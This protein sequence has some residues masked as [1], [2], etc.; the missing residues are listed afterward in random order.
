MTTIY[1]PATSIQYDVDLF[2]SDL[3]GYTSDNALDTSLGDGT[4]WGF[5]VL[6]VTT[7][8]NID[9][10]WDVP[11]STFVGGTKGFVKSAVLHVVYD[12]DFNDSEQPTAEGYDPCLVCPH[13][14]IQ[15]VWETPGPFSSQGL[16]AT[17]TLLSGDDPFHVTVGPEA[18]LV[19][20]SE[21]A[22]P[23]LTHVTIPL[24]LTLDDY[25]PTLRFRYTSGPSGHSD[26]E[27]QHIHAVYLEIDWAP[28]HG[29]TEKWPNRTE[30]TTTYASGLQIL[31]AGDA[32]AAFTPDTGVWRV[33]TSGHPVGYKSWADPLAPTVRTFVP[34]TEHH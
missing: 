25:L 14:A 34:I 8:G 21:S 13:L 32:D 29:F 23:L 10:K 2:P 30:W 20:M 5:D 9:F 26:P 27:Q 17:K 1:F 28:D 4:R 11:V 16:Y 15:A 6:D 18:T 22:W 31:S 7:G 3:G 24:D 19:G 33:A 12:A